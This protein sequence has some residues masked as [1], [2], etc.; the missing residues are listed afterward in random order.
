MS[1]TV[2]QRHHDGSTAD[3]GN[4]QY[5]LRERAVPTT[6]RTVG[7]TSSEIEKYQL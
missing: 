3:H 6:S 2:R 7:M 4:G 5:Q 1:A